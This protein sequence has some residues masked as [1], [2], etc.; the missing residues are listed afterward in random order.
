MPYAPPPRFQPSVLDAG[1]AFGSCFFVLLG[2]VVF[3]NFFTLFIG[4]RHGRSHATMGL[5][6]LF[7]LIA[8]FAEAVSAISF[9]KYQRLGI[10]VLL[11]LSGALLTL[12]ASWDFKHKNIKNVASGVLDQHATVTNGE[13]VE[14]VFYQG[15]NL[16][17]ICFLHA[18]P[19]APQYSFLLLFLVTAPWL[20]R[21]RFP[22][23]S[24]RDNYHKR[25]PKSSVLVRV[26]YRVKKWQ[27]VFYKFVLLHGLNIG[28]ALMH[29]DVAHSRAFRAYW[30]L[31][32][33]AYVMEFFLQTLVKKGYLA[34]PIMLAL[35]ALL[36][37]SSSCAAVCFLF[38]FYF[39]QP[40]LLLVAAASCALNFGLGG[41]RD[42]TYTMSIYSVAKLLL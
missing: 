3:R 26:L 4:R 31:L 28:V 37:L 18:V 41:G 22:L 24:F 39:P 11:G 32:N 34:Q 17:Q 15:L 36:M 40:K 35:N 33:T 9:A 25:D 10:D 29:S 14:H 42:L 23:N 30:A 6:H 8:E 5:V 27:Y 13:M 21:K 16:L 12:T 19:L 38:A 2:L 1:L 7:V 20:V